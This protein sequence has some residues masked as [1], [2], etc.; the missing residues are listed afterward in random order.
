MCIYSLFLIVC[1]NDVCS[2]SPSKSA[3]LTEKRRGMCVKFYYQVLSPAIPSLC[4]RL[5]KMQKIPGLL[6]FCLLW[7][8]LLLYIALSAPPNH[9]IQNPRREGIYCVR[10]STLDS[11]K[12][13]HSEWLP[14]KS[15]R[16]RGFGLKKKIL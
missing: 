1:I 2:N 4:I 9:L 11:L 6:L 8:M 5:K 10:N 7:A 12:K 15:N 14:G 3:T 13:V 16:D